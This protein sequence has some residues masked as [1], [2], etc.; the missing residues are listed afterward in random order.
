MMNGEI[1]FCDVGRITHS[2]I[3]YS[4]SN[5]SDKIRFHRFG[6]LEGKFKLAMTAL[7]IRQP[8]HAMTMVVV[9]AQC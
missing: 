8:L 9:V 5:K 2:Q 1:N 7:T 6:V 3:E 4:H